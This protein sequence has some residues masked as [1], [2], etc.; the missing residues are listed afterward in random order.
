MLGIKTK[1]RHIKEDDETEAT[2][3]HMCSQNARPTRTLWLPTTT[4]EGS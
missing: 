4:Q 1:K 2:R 3:S